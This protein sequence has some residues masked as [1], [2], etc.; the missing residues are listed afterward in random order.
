[1]CKTFYSG[2]H[3]N[4]HLLNSLNRGQNICVVNSTYRTCS[5]KRLLKLLFQGNYKASSTDCVTYIKCTYLRFL[6]S[7]LLI[8]VQCIHS[9]KNTINRY[10]RPIE[11]FTYVHYKKLLK[12]GS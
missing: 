2:P 1:M 10:F 3:L 8:K 9:M 12:K 6:N 5:K 7:V 11:K 4:Y